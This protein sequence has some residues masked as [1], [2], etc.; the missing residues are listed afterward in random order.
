MQK[1]LPKLT[2]EETGVVELGFF[3]RRRSARAGYF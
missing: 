1:K 2:P 3:E